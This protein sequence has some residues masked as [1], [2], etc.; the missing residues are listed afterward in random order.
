MGSVRP[1]DAPRVIR[2]DELAAYLEATEPQ[3]KVLPAGAFKE[4]LRRSRQPG[5]AVDLG[6]LPWTKASANFAFRP[7]EVTLWAG[8]NGSGKSMMLS[9]VQLSL[10]AQGFRCCSASFEMKPFRQLK[11][12]TR[13]A[14]M[15]MS[16]SDE[17]E[18]ELVDYLNA[19]RLW[20]Y[21]QQGTVRPK[22]VFAVC[23]YVADKL[24]MHHV[25]IDS[26][27]KCVRGEEDWDAQKDF[28]DEITA[29][30]RDSN[31]HIHIVHHLRKRDDERAVPTKGSVRGHGSIVDQVDNLMLVWRN[32]GKEVDAAKGKDVDET[33]PDQMILVE[34]QRNGEWEGRISLWFHKGAMQYTSDPSCRPL[35]LYSM[36][37]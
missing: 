22:Q 27:M 11:R 14:S 9:Q 28:I 13:Q 2:P 33:I 23:R 36:G 26:L 4:E 24:G 5:Y 34:K 21:D 8:E 1:I 32:K 6:F 7:G 30:A 17:F 3:Q 29:I 18:D 35:E 19:N 15:G 37:W 10:I 20:F 12:M 31:M 25:F 16:P